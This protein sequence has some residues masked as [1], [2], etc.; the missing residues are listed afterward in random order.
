MKRVGKPLEPGYTDLEITLIEYEQ[1]LA[2]L[3]VRSP[4][5]ENSTK[6][7]FLRYT[8]NFLRK[9]L[10]INQNERWL[11]FNKGY[12]EKVIRPINVFL[13]Q[14]A[15]RLF[16]QQELESD[17]TQQTEADWV[18]HIPHEKVVQAAKLVR[19]SVLRAHAN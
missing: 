17:E 19:E 5:P 6:G 3:N 16:S 15:T 2:L 7:L 8:R 12:Q 18:R 9:I 10:V 4:L 11:P 1:I 13:L 14:F